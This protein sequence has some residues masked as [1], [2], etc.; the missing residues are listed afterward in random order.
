[1]TDSIAEYRSTPN[2]CVCAHPTEIPM[3]SSSK[4]KE[5]S[6][7]VPSLLVILIS[8]KQFWKESGD[9]T[10]RSLG[11]VADEVTDILHGN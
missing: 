7:G 3:M 9:G 8:N 6:S 2:G 1:M 10:S 11:A 5:A 4:I